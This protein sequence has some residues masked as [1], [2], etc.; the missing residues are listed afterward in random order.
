V[1][2]LGWS[3]CALASIVTGAGL[4]AGGRS[5]RAVALE[6]RL[7]LASLDLMVTD[8]LPHRPLYQKLGHVPRLLRAPMTISAPTD[9]ATCPKARTS[10]E[11]ET[12]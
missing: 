1:S 11:G 6:V 2:S 8:A 5:V 3:D 10:T 4:L 12:T 7:V 9:S